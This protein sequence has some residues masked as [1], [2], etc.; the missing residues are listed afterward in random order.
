LRL[1]GIQAIT[2]VDHSFILRERPVDFIEK[3]KPA[4]VVKGKEHEERENPEKDV[5]KQYG[6][7]LI[8]G[9]GEISFSS[10]DLMNTE[11]KELSLSSIKKPTDYPKRHR[12]SFPELV[13]I[14]DQ[15][16]H[17]KVCVLGDI[18]VDEYI[19]VMP[20]ACRRRTPRLS[21]RP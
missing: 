21:S 10:V 3:L 1:E 14:A 18:I 13:E 15:I 16:K 6:G 20:S 12:F 17:L 8:F 9:S 11:W 2:W 5:L 4:F 19:P 7:K